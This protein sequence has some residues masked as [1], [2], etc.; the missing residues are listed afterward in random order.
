MSVYEEGVLKFAGVIPVG[1]DSVTNDIALGA[2]TSID[3]A[4][5]LKLMH[6][7]IGLDAATDKEFNINLSDINR[8]EE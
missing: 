8:T 1:G 5:R 4:E 2:R 3:T 6:A 7:E